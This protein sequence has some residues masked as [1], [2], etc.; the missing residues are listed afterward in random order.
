MEFKLEDSKGFEV[1]FESDLSVKCLSGICK[2]KM[3]GRYHTNTAPNGKHSF[4]MKMYIIEDK[5]ETRSKQMVLIVGGLQDKH[6]EVIRC[7]WE[8]FKKG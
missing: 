6:S 8:L 2:G 1:P 5:K 3:K 4:E 7:G